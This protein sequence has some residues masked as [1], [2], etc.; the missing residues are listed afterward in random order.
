MEFRTISQEQTEKLKQP[1]DSRQ[2]DGTAR[3]TRQQ[4]PKPYASIQKQSKKHKQSC[5][6]Q[7]GNLIFQI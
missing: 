2:P 4:Q 5:V 3:V 6:H 1:T 7:G